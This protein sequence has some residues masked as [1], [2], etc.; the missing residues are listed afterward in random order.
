M[1]CSTDKDIMV[2][3]QKDQ[4]VTIFTI[5]SITGKFIEKLAKKS[6]KNNK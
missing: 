5:H 3:L 2:E 4:K 6:F 1:S